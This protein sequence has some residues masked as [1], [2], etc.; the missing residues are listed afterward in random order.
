LQL[1]GVGV[2]AGSLDYSKLPFLCR[3]IAKAMGELEGGYRL[4]AKV[5]RQ[6]RTCIKGI[7]LHKERRVE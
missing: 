4:A 2:F 5:V 7:P 6:Y 1:A 3:M